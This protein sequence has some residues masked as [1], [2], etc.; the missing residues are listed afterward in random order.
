MSGFRREPLHDFVHMREKSLPPVFV[1]RRDIINECLTIAQKTGQH[2]N[3]IPGNTTVIQG[4]PGAG[5]TSVLGIIQQ[6]ASTV[7]ARVVRVGNNAVE[8]DLPDVLKA[9]ACAGSYDHAHWNALWERFG[10]TWARRIVGDGALEIHS[11]DSLRT[12]QKHI[13]PEIWTAP[14][15]VAIDEVQRFQNAEAEARPHIQRFLQEIH[16]SDDV[17]LPIT[18]VLAGLG[19][20]HNVIRDMGLTHG[21]HPHALGCFSLGEL[22]HL[23]TEWCAH[24]G[25]DIGRQR[26]RID[27]L[28]A[29][30]EGW[31]RHVHWAQRALAEALLAEG[32]DGR[33]DRLLDWDAVH[34]RAGALR[35]GYYQ[36]QYSPVMA[37]A[38]SLT[39]HVISTIAGTPCHTLEDL[40]KTIE[41]A[42]EPDK[43]SRCRLPK[44]YDAEAFVTHLIHSGALQ[45]T[46]DGR[47]FSCPIPSFENYMLARGGSCSSRVFSSTR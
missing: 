27:A 21:I 19:D 22:N 35:Q 11:Y 46:P 12:L 20:T 45:H 3:G 16:D 1:G 37:S 17:R 40:V 33:V 31:P 9:I 24:F 5:K 36:H 6:R 41:S 47:G 38:T 28:M 43:E 29:E 2:K 25:I 32:V 18:L 26:E 8:H 42:C 23:T 34:R 39:T 4:A 30:A 14:V 15:I 7:G 44:G 10:I 13:A